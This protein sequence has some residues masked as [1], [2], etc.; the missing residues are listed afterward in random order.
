MLKRLTTRHVDVL[1]MT[2]ALAVS[3]VGYMVLFTHINY[4]LN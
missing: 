2:S 1:I 4:V 3:I